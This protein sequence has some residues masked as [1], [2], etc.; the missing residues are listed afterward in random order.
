MVSPKEA[1]PS[2][3]VELAWNALASS[4]LRVTRA[5]RGILQVLASQH[6]P[7]SAVEVFERLE[8]GVCDLVTTYRTLTALE[9]V[10]LIRR[11]DFGDSCYRYEFNTGEHHHHHII[12]RKCRKVETVD[13]C[14]AD[15][16][17]RLASRRGY[18]EITHTLEVFAICSQCAKD[19]KSDE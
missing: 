13:L 15:A 1:Q 4:R 16:L 3:D 9:E 7:F 2:R 19:H 6:G 14:V 10:G 12:C 18:R 8:Q 5:R 11:C 17:E